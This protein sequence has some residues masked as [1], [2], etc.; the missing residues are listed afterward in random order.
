MTLRW[1]RLLVLCFGVFALTG[2]LAQ[3]ADDPIDPAGRPKDLQVGKTTGFGVWEEKGTWHIR[4]TSAK[5]SGKSQRVVFQGRVTI[6]GD[7]LVKGNFEGLETKS[8]TNPEWVVVND[9][10]TVFDFQFSTL[11]GN[12]DGLSFTVGPNTESINIHIL[13]AGQEIPKAIVIGSKSANP[14]KAQFS[15]PVKPPEK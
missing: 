8:K 3:S 9:K 13:I 7:K 4:T 10:Q 6:K 15:L 5:V 1:F 2:T 14:K 11:S 12:S